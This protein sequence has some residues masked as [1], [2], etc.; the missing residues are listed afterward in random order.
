MEYLICL[1]QKNNKIIGCTAISLSSDLKEVQIKNH[2]LGTKKLDNASITLK[3]IKSTNGA[4]SRYPINC[5]GKIQNSNSFILLGYYGDEDN[6]NYVYC[7]YKGTIYKDTINTLG[8]KMFANAKIVTKG[9]RFLAFISGECPILDIKEQPKEV[10]NQS[11]NNKP[12][13]IDTSDMKQVL[14]KAKPVNAQF[15]I[16]TG[17]VQ[18]F[19]SSYMNNLR[20]FIKDPNILSKLGEK[21]AALNLNPVKVQAPPITQELKNK[22]YNFSMLGVAA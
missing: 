3:T 17:N 16:E 9:T 19:L 12:I 10:V 7:D 13:E 14:Q 15:L 18:E 6:K 1:Q 11:I 20:E 8:S 4:I 22:N 2:T 21:L 5:E